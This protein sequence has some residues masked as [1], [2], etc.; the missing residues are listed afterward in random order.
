[1]TKG[2]LKDADVLINKDGA[3]TGK[4]GLYKNDNSAPACINE[5]LF[6]IRGDAPKITQSY[7]YYTL[8]SQPCQNQIDAQISGSAQ[9]GP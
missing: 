6:L 7:L 4:V 5:H 8:L 1:M 9:P 3:Q 2:H